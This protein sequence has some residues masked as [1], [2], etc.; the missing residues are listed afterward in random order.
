MLDKSLL[1]PILDELPAVSSKE[2]YEAS[3]RRWQAAGGPVR[4]KAMV[5][6][7]GDQL[8]EVRT[9][10]AAQYAPATVKRCFIVAARV[11]ASLEETEEKPTPFK[12][13]RVVVGDNTPQWNV[14]HEGELK[15]VADAL[16]LKRKL[17]E[18]AVI[19]TLG[20]QGWRRHVV[21]DLKWCDVRQ[22]EDGFVAE[23][24][25]KR[26]RVLLQHVHHEVMAAVRVLTSTRPPGPE[27]PFISGPDGGHL[28][29][30]QVYRMVVHSV[31]LVLGRKV[32]PHGLRAT[33][34]STVVRQKGDVMLASR[35]AGHRQL[36]TTE[37]YLR[38]QMTGT[39][40]DEVKL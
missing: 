4:R 35:L 31:Q 5:H 1:Q 39:K 3:W 30:I 40:R 36:A 6:L 28:T 14:L 10:L 38:W 21:C 16:Q 33:F 20:L 26:G 24:K 11:W 12:R 19:L 27:E 37:R 8:R 32:T 15:K 2:A 23:V 34:I 25:S 9:K 7:T 29:P 17:L 13:V 18:R 22:T